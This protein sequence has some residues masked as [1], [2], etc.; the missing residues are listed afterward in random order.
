MKQHFYL[1]KELSD[2]TYGYVDLRIRQTFLKINEVG[3]SL[4][5]KPRTVSVAMLTAQLLSENPDL[6][7]SVSATLRLTGSSLTDFSKITEDMNKM[8]PFKI[9]Y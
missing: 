1:R 7:K 3:S 2:K 5:G 8:I 4:Q 6:G 9:P